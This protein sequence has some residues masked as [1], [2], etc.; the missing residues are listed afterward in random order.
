M[1][2]ARMDELL[3]GAHRAASD[4]AQ[5]PQQEQTGVRIDS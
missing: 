4:K 5:P 2:F 3:R 1:E